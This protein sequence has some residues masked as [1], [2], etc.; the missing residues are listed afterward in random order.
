MATRCDPNFVSCAVKFRPIA[1]LRPSTSKNSRVTR[2]P[3]SRSGSPPPARLKPASPNA[4]IPEK[5]G[6][7]VPPH[8]GLAPQHSK[9]PPCAPR[10]G[11]PLGFPAAG[12]VETSLAERGDSRETVVLIA[13]PHIIPR[14]H[15]E[16]WKA[17]LQIALANQ[18]QLL[19]FRVAQRLEQHGVDHREDGGIRPNPQCQSQHR[20]AGEPRISPKRPES[21]P[22]IPQK[23]RKHG[24]SVRR[25]GGTAVSKPGGASA[26]QRPLAGA[27]LLVFAHHRWYRKADGKLVGRELSDNRVCPSGHWP[28]SSPLPAR[29]GSPSRGP[30]AR[31]TTGARH[32]RL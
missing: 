29:H 11:E 9:D 13:V 15:G 27:Q 5:L 2:V 1:G 10:P 22:Q 31:M 32:P 25:S 7:E 17:G 12:Q 24:Y 20:N 14:G 26:C 8:R 3:A 21:I 4:A 16:L 6:S 23:R 30:T 18:H 28:A 19:R